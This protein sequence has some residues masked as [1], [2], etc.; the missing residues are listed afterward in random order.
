MTKQEGERNMFNTSAFAFNFLRNVLL[1]LALVY[2]IA[3]LR[4][5][6]N[7][8]LESE[9]MRIKKPVFTLL[10][11]AV[12][13]FT[14]GFLFTNPFELPSQSL[15]TLLNTIFFTI[16][17]ACFIIALSYFWHMSAKMHRLNVYEAFFIL[18][19]SSG[20]FIWL[21]F[22][23]ETSLMPASISLPFYKKAL[24]LLHPLAVALIFL[25]T[26]TIHP[27]Y[28]A[29]VIRT[30]LLYISS[31]IFTYFLGFMIFAYSLVNEVMGFLHILY[32]VLFLISA[33]YFFLGFYVAEENFKE[34]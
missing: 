32:S 26:L 21:H 12:F 23:F 17:Y 3:C 9:I 6:W 13:F 19:V 20:V 8:R 24:L 28:K 31:A 15:F 5:L 33:V 2:A 14:L 16:S 34:E 27:K 7:R 30:P 18:G 29:K 1:C 25:L 22:L 10:A 11:A 4:H